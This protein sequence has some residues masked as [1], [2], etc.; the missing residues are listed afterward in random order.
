MDFYLPP[1]KEFDAHHEMGELE[2]DIVAGE[3]RFHATCPGASLADPRGR[4]D[5]CCSEWLRDPAG[6]HGEREHRDGHDTSGP[7]RNPGPPA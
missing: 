5:G 4:D 3:R 6:H 2:T 1:E 7:G